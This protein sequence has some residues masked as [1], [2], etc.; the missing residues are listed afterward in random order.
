MRKTCASY[1]V[2]TIIVSSGSTLNP[3]SPVLSRVAFGQHWRR[4]LEL[5]TDVSLQIE[6]QA[7]ATSR[8]LLGSTSNLRRVRPVTRICATP[9]ERLLVNSRL[10][11]RNS[12]NSSTKFT[13]M[14]TFDRPQSRSVRSAPAEEASR[15]LSASLSIAKA[16]RMG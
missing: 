4:L 8:N 7:C 2:M 13:Q 6:I 10:V 1:I 11:K 14:G 5:S 16:A 15:T 3:I 9:F 12:A